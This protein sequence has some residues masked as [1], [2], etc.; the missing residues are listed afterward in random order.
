MESQIKKKKIRHSTTIYLPRKNNE[1]IAKAI[2]V[3]A[4]NLYGTESLGKASKYIMGLIKKDFIA[5]GLFT[6]QGEPLVDKLQEM[7]K[8]NQKITGGD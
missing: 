6:S 5:A 2:K 8:E 3:R 4:E 7:E 1:F